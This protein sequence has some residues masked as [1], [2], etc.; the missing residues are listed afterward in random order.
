LRTGWYKYNAI[1]LGNIL[2]KKFG[3]KKLR[4]LD[5]WEF[6][7]IP[8]IGKAKAC[9]LV[10][11]FELSRRVSSVRECDRKEISD[12]KELYKLYGEEMQS[13]KQ[14]ILK[15][16]FLDSRNRIIYSENIF[17]GSL[18][19]NLIHPREIFKKALD[20]SASSIILMHNHPSGDPEPS[21][22]DINVTKKLLMLYTN[23]LKLNQ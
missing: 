16:V 10:A 20:C 7:K 19:E 6:R 12:V 18:D 3:L 9:Q 22:N 5:Y 2:L 15:A 21:R 13:N 11:S 4:Q 8:G 17:K 14:E 1:D 23:Q